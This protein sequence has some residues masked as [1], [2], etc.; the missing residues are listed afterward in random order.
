MSINVAPELA[1]TTKLCPKKD[2]IISKFYQL[3]DRLTSKYAARNAS[4]TA[5]YEKQA[6]AVAN[7]LDVESTYRTASDK[8]AKEKEGASFAEQ[9]YEKWKVALADTKKR[10]E[11]E[12]QDDIASKA[13]NDSERAII[14]ELL[15]LID[16]L[17]TTEASSVN[18]QTIL[19]QFRQKV[20]KK[21]SC[22]NSFSLHPHP[23]CLCALAAFRAGGEGR[24]R[25]WSRLGKGK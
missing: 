16:E 5:A 9:Q 3:L 8:A 7:W 11:K 12:I 22:S 6:Q 25:I 18:R 20:S 4:D 14:M 2:V 1:E 24:Q 19:K 21:C 13:D 10:Q 15:R 17:Q 23:C